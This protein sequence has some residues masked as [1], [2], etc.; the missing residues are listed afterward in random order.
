MVN[1][2]LIQVVM[3]SRV[4]YGMA[5]QGLAPSRFGRVDARRRTPTLATNAVAAAMI[6]LII[7]F[8]LVELAELTSVVTLGVFAMVNAAL[9]AIGRRTPGTALGRFRWVGLLGATSCISLASWQ[10]ADAVR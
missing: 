8:P 9:F 7:F 6:T 5:N 1:G 3:A 10:F 2:I 4:L